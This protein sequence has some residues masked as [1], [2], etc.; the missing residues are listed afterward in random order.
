MCLG[1]FAELAVQGRQDVGGRQLERTPGEPRVD[2]V[3]P[4]VD[5]RP[6][7]AGLLAE[8]EQLLDDLVDGVPAITSRSS[9]SRSSPP[10]RACRVGLEEVRAARA[11]QLEA[12]CWK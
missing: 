10:S 3:D 4:A 1:V 6:E 11:D 5:E 7:R 12:S 2:P 9:S 8:G